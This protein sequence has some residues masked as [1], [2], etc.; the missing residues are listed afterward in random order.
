MC[1]AN[2]TR[3]MPT[4]II[5]I[6]PARL[7]EDDPFG[8]HEPLTFDDLERI[9]QAL[10]EGTVS[11][12]EADRLRAIRDEEPAELAEAFRGI[13]N[14]LSAHFGDVFPKFDIGPKYT[15]L[16]PKLDL[17]LDLTDVLPKLDIG[18]KY[19]AD[20]FPKLDIGLDVSALLPKADFAQML[21]DAPRSP[22][23]TLIPLPDSTQ[24]RCWSSIE[25]LD[26]NLFVDQRPAHMEQLAERQLEALEA[27]CVS[28]EATA[29]AIVKSDQRAE[30][31]FEETKRM[32]R[33][34]THI[35]V[36]VTIVAALLS[37]LAGA[38]LATFLR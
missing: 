19:T 31:R 5:H 16:F 28:L 14:T 38:L 36:V 12:A 2:Y 9:E 25:S 8:L 32:N 23:D 4:K 21:C 33:A 7:L 34:Q 1:Q 18:R 26:L 3:V 22:I 24:E 15:D 10:A 20:L 27:A 6:T 30:E 35:V 11:G 37:G 29:E 13:I 17:G